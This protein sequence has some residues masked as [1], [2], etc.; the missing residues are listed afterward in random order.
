MA[1]HPYDYSFALKKEIQRKALFVVLIFFLLCVVIQLVTVFLIFPVR[2]QTTGMNPEYPENS[3]V[4]VVPYSPAHPLFFQRYHIQRGSVVYVDPLDDR[5][6]SFVKRAA[7]FIINFFTFR[8]TGIIKPENEISGVPSLRRVVGLPG[9]TLYMQDY[10]LYVRTAG[11]SHFLT[12][13]EVTDRMYEIATDSVKHDY[14]IGVTGN[15]DEFTLGEDEYFLLADE[16]VSSLDS[17]MYGPVKA[18]RISGKAVLRYFPFDVFD[19]L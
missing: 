17:R 19:T 15:F 7:D 4:F 13:F 10:V 16:R 11:E 3:L 12:E 18:D 5:D 6:V 9:D 2:V 8:Q 14:E 1:S